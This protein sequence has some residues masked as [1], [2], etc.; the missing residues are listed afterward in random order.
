MKKYQIL[1]S[2]TF[3]FLVVECSIYLDRLIFVMIILL[4]RRGTGVSHRSL[5]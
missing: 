5:H 2:E 4:I 1:L 3:H